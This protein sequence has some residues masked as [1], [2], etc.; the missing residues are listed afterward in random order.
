MSKFHWRE[1]PE[2]VARLVNLDKI[3]TYF[4]R[5]VT[6]KP[7]EA[8]VFL[9]EGKIGNAITGKTVRDVGGGFSR[10]LGDILKLTADDRRIIFAM[11]GPMD[12][13]IP[14]K[15]QILDGSDVKGHLNLRLQ[16]SEDN[17]PKLLNI[18]S[19]QSPILTRDGIVKI[20]QNEVISRLIEPVFSKVEHNDDLRKNSFQSRIESIAETELRSILSVT[21]LKLL[22]AFAIIGR[23]DYEKILQLRAEMRN[24]T[25]IEG[26]NAKALAERI[27]IREQSML[28]RIEC[29]VNIAKAKARGEVD[30]DLEKELKDLRIKEAH[31]QSE[32]NKLQDKSEI[33]KSIR[34]NKTE[35]AMKLFESVQEAKRLRIQNEH[36]NEKDIIEQQNIF[37]EKMMQLAAE[38]DA[39][40]SSVVKTLLEQQSAQKAIGKGMN[41]LQ[42]S[43]VEV[44]DLTCQSCGKG[45]QSD[46]LLCP[47]CGHDF[48]G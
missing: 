36:S 3:Q 18:F 31:W 5:Q 45:R 41:H 10:F 2:I 21:G 38:K 22:S 25:Q 8:A 29:E 43:R 47:Y 30:I 42:P 19:N 15:T 7:N 40:D 24:A 33:L 9:V 27:E 35:N 4:S 32:L 16:I 11:T 12:I 44:K 48:G 13:W 1:T 26:E 14:F 46:W 39:L 28:R 34:E 6:L 37:Q 20:L 23:T 17:I